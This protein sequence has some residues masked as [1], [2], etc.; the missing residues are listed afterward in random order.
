[1]G[2]KTSQNILAIGSADRIRFV[3]TKETAKYLAKEKKKAA[4]KPDETLP[5][6]FRSIKS[7]YLVPLDT[8]KPVKWFKVIKRGKQ[9]GFHFDCGSV[10][11][12][13]EFKKWGLP[14]HAVAGG[15]PG[16]DQAQSLPFPR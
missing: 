13:G 10:D 14:P 1:T 4:L 6:P 11:N 16:P 5:S 2:L 7:P 15:Q 8:E 3:T 9:N 12:R